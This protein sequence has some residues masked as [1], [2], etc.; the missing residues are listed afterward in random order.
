MPT[1]QKLFFILLIF[2]LCLSCLPSFARVIDKIL[3][4]VNDEI[5][6]QSDVNKILAPMYEQLRSVY[7]GRELE[8]KMAATRHNVLN[9]LIDTKLLL[10]EAKRKGVEITN[11][12]VAKRIDEVKSSFDTEEEFVAALANENILLS[13]LEQKFK[14][15]LMTEAIIG[16]EMATRISVSP[17]EVLQYYNDNISEFQ[18]SQKVKARSILIKKGK[19]YDDEEARALA[20]EILRR[21][22]GGGDFNSLATMHSEGPYAEYGGEMGWV[23]EGKLLEPVDRVLFRLNKGETSPVIETKL[24]FHILR[25]DDE[26]VKEVKEFSEVKKEIEG[27]LFGQKKGRK[28]TGWLGELKENAY[29]SFK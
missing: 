23:E 5:I 18:E 17:N 16:A 9:K 27:F 12:E 6:T 8:E 13:E 19:N 26:K 4:A 14:E 20:E 7:S 28:L 29:I 10:A 3:V 11:E 15:K 2:F 25:V 24:G 1:K 22:A 21:L